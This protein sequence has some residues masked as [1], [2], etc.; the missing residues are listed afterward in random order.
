M[1]QCEG[2]LEVDEKYHFAEFPHERRNTCSNKKRLLIV[3]SFCMK[4]G[5]RYFTRPVFA[6]DYNTHLYTL[7]EARRVFFVLFFVLP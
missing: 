5:E 7:G 4:K 3:D 6:Y 1:S 2:A